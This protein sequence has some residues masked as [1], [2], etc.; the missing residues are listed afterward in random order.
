MADLYLQTT[1]RFELII[2]ALLS[3]T[4]ENHLVYDSLLGRLLHLDNPEHFRVL[5][6]ATP[7]ALDRLL[8][9]ERSALDHADDMLGLS[10]KRAV[11]AGIAGSSGGRRQEHK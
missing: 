7:E 6:D 10:S 4:Q 8:K 5:A 1:R 11:V 3:S 2:Q 9:I